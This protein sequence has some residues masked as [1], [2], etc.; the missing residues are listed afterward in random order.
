MAGYFAL[1]ERSIDVVYNGVDTERFRP[2]KKDRKD[3][4]RILFS[5][6]NFR[7][8]G[9]GQLISALSVIQ[10]ERR[11]F[12]LS[13]MGRGKRGRYEKRIR[14]MGLSDLVEFM[15]ERANPESIYGGADILVHPTYY[16]A[17]SLTTMEAMAS[18]LPVITT[19]WNGASALIEDEGF[20]I[21]E[22]DRID[23][24]VSAIKRLFHEETREYMGRRAR[25]MMEGYTMEI[26]AERME[27]II[28][29]SEG[30]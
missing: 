24:M 10:R 9:L 14:D 20:V 2:I 21:D 3:H 4:L 23:S 29:E 17:C 16:D 1:D 28:K 15:G 11:D 19:R 8:K 30:L 7:L 6:G 5:A 26:N 13:V 25:A 12:R 22:P 18:G 27:K